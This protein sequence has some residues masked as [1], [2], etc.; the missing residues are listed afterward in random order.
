VPGQYQQMVRLQQNGMTMNQQAD[1][2]QKA[3]HNTARNQ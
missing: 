1:L 2:R 3:I